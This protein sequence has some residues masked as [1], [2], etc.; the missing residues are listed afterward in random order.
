[1]NTATAILLLTALLGFLLYRLQHKKA[2]RFSLAETYLLFGIKVLAGIAYGYIFKEYYQG[3][4][5]WAIHEQGLEEYH[6]LLQHP[7]QYLGELGPQSAIAGSRDAGQ[8]IQFYLMDLENNLFSKLLGVFNLISRGNYYIN[9]VFFNW[10]SFWG[11]YWIFSIMV[12]IAPNH[13]RFFYITLT[14]VP[15]VVFWLSGIRAD[16]LILFFFGWVSYSVFSYMGNKRVKALLGILGGM[17]GLLI[18]RNALAGLLLPCLSA[19]WFI[20]YKGWKPLQSFCI[21]WGI[22]ILLF[23][24]TGLLQSRF[25]L[26][27][28]VVTRQ[29]EFFALSGNTRLPLDSLQPAAGSFIHNLPQAIGNSFFRPLL[30]EA[31]GPLQLMSATENLL[32]L[33]ILLLFFIR[34]NK[35]WKLNLGHPMGIGFVFFALALYLF[36][37][38]T[39]PFPG[40]IVRYRVL[41][42]LLLL[43]VLVSGIRWEEKTN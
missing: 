30:W 3:D 31:R 43:L 15:A 9:V 27:Q 38:Y 19:W 2:I 12:R 40:A 7:L 10:F 17:L 33:I 37:G 11:L 35:N 16:G 32:I 22:A 42:E 29:Q 34:R 4:D 21:S 25:N 23:F 6:K 36:I 14:L 8:A 41:G 26:P 1:M 39:I 18:F 20:S 24:A 13:R 28:V 5:T